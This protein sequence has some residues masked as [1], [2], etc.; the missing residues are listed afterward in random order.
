MIH[1]CQAFKKTDHA[2]SKILELALGEKS[3][4]LFIR[5]T[6]CLYE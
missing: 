5:Q 1:E 3:V 4:L 2:A 6:D